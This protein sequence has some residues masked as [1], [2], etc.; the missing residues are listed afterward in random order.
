VSDDERIRW[1]E[2][3]RSG[4]YADRKHPTPLLADWAPRLPSGRALDVAC[5]AGRNSLY[6][7]ASGWK[8]DGADISPVGLARARE[9]AEEQGLDI[10]WLQADLDGDPDKALPQGPY[11]LI[12][13]VRYVNRKLYPHL[14]RRL[15]PGGMFLCEQH[16]ES[17][18]DVIGPKTPAFRLRHN[19]LLRD[20]LAAAGDGGRLLY[21]REGLVTDPDGRRA[22]LAQLV[23]QAAG[24]RRG[25]GE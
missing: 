6:L 7:A 18:E 24:G 23:F 21:Y 13:V 3:Y 16:I 17:D 4:A 14:F 20:V 22:A 9:N 8:V 11:D 25:D 12:V 1:D 5:G 10:G 15:R 19:E 2:K